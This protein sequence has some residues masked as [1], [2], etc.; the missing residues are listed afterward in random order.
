MKETDVPVL[1]NKKTDVAKTK[2]SGFDMY[3]TFVS[4]FLTKE[5]IGI[6]AGMSFKIPDDDMP[7]TSKESNKITIEC[8]KPEETDRRLVITYEETPKEKTKE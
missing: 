6:I 5:D 7:N 2:N 1:V 3:K 4:Q 8:D